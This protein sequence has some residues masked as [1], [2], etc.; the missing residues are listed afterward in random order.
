MAHH[1]DILLSESAFDMRYRN[2]CLMMY[3]VVIIYSYSKASQN[4]AP[5]VI[6]ELAFVL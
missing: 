4:M 2:E 3:D 5:D 6:Y 1:V